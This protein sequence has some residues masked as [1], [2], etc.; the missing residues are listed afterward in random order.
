MYVCVRHMVREL[1]APSSRAL[2]EC[3]YRFDVAIV[4]EYRTSKLDCDDIPPGC[5]ELRNAIVMDS[6]PLLEAACN[7]V[8]EHVEFNLERTAELK[9]RKVLGFVRRDDMIDMMK[10]DVVFKA[11]KKSSLKVLLDTAMAQRGHPFVADT[12][13]GSERERVTSSYLNCSLKF[14]VGDMEQDP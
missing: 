8:D 10:R 6:D 12:R 13:L 1:S 14:H 3:R 11:A 4:D 9:G 5:L 2:K 7:F